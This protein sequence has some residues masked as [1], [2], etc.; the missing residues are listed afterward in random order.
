MFHYFF[1]H[2]AGVEDREEGS[3]GQQSRTTADCSQRFVNYYVPTKNLANFN[4]PD[5]SSDSSSGW[6]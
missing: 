4:R 1:L 2:V 5:S 3:V 6:G